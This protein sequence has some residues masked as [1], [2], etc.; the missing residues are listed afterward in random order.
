MN[1]E[2]ISGFKN[3]AAFEKILNDAL[4]DILLEERIITISA[5]STGKANS[6]LEGEAA[7]D[8][9]VKISPYSN[10][11]DILDASFSVVAKDSTKGDSASS[12]DTASLLV[13]FTVKKHAQFYEDVYKIILTDLINEG[14][15]HT[16]FGG[17]GTHIFVNGNTGIG[18]NYLPLSRAYLTL[19]GKSSI[20]KNDELLTTDAFTHFF[21]T[22]AIRDENK[23]LMQ[24]TDDTRTEAYLLLSGKYGG[25]SIPGTDQ[26]FIYLYWDTLDLR[27]EQ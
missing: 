7:L 20:Y 5:K 25:S 23:Q 13:T 1:N 10:K 18:T 16:Y 19:W 4:F 11:L 9:T 3:F 17:V 6:I 24:R 15:D 14:I 12:K 21:I 2:R 8:P 27:Q 26:G 22:T